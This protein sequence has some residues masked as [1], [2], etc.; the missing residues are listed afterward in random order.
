MKT[1]AEARKAVP[2]K[3]WCSASFGNPGC[4]GYS[5]YWRSGERRWEISNGPWCGPE[6]WTVTEI[7]VLW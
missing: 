2:A 4:G 3:A 5:E 1:Y 6:E 7:P